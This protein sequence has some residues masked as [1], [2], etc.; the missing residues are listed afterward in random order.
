LLD[1]LVRFFTNDLTIFI[2]FDENRYDEKN[3]M[4]KPCPFDV[5]NK[6][7]LHCGTCVYG[8]TYIDEQYI[9]IVNR[10]L[11]FILIGSSNII[12]EHSL[13]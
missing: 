1:N 6:N 7:V 8:R 2:K 4:R 10:V 5:T 3:T 12:I 11:V 9:I 13:E